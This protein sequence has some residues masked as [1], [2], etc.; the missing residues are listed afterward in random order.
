MFPYPFGRDWLTKSLPKHTK[1]I[2]HRV[3]FYMRLKEAAKK[4][5]VFSGPTTERG[6]GKSP[7]TKEKGTFKKLFFYL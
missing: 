5:S 3:P 4:I 7:T 2:L 1:Y 6:G